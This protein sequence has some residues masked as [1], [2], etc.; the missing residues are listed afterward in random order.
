MVSHKMSSYDFITTLVRICRWGATRERMRI[1]LSLLASWLFK[2]QGTFPLNISNDCFNSQGCWLSQTGSTVLLRE[3]RSKPSRHLSG[4]RG[5][6]NSHPN[7]TPIKL[8]KQ[9]ILYIWLTY[10]FSGYQSVCMLRSYYR[11][12]FNF[13]L[14]SSQRWF[15]HMWDMTHVSHDTKT[16]KSIWKSDH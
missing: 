3:R 12:M 8:V 9:L 7:F 14:Q 15:L 13:T 16:W 4:E 5:D 2:V 1:C 11:K 6:V 10:K